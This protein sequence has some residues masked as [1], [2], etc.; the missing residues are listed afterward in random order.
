MN[1]PKCGY[2]M[3]DFDVDCPRCKRIKEQAPVAQNVPQPSIQYPAVAQ[4][5]VIVPP[6]PPG[7]ST[8]STPALSATAIGC[9]VIAGCL[10]LSGVMCS[11]CMRTTP[12]KK[13]YT[14]EQYD[15]FVERFKVLTRDQGQIF[16]QN[17]TLEIHDTIMTLT[18]NYADT[19]SASKRSLSDTADIMAR[20][21]MSW[22]PKDEKLYV[23]IN[24]YQQMKDIYSDV[25]TWTYSGAKE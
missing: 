20:A 21:Y 12:E 5:P 13:Y 22:F 23:I 6:V 7:V 24:D 16:G 9:I 1:C 4:S 17:Y 3:S 14:Q 18:L 25:Y 2:A 15:S 19:A 10:I 11:S 8:R